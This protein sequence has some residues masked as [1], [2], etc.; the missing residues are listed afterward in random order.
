MQHLPFPARFV[1]AAAAALAV[2]ACSTSA[3]RPPTAPDAVAVA[4]V[5]APGSRFAAL[6]LGMDMDKV[7]EI[8][9][10]SPDRTHSYE[11]GKRWIPFYFA[12]D[13]RRLEALYKGEGCLVF[14]GG[15][16]W[17]GG[18]GE[19]IRVEADASGACYDS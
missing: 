4:A 3:P 11:T 12:S 13:A 10:R 16:L 7:Q 2:G 17:G 9:G 14:T 19:L 18:G 5:P 15:N 1:L 8:L 6:K